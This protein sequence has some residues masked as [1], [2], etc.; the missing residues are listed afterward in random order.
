[1]KPTKIIRSEVFKKNINYIYYFRL[2]CRINHCNPYYMTEVKQAL[3]PRS[4]P[5]PVGTW[6]PFSIRFPYFIRRVF[7]GTL[8]E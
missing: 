2:V 7:V 8:F 3:H 1:M 6:S 4:I 5:S